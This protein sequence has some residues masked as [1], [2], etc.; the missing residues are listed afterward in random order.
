VR[1][2]DVR[3]AL[4]RKVLKEHHGDANT[5]NPWNLIA[6]CSLVVTLAPF[7]LALEA[8]ENRWRGLPTRRPQSS[9]GCTIQYLLSR[10]RHSNDLPRLPAMMA[11]R[12]TTDKVPSAHRAAV[13]KSAVRLC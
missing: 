5:L 11:R 6:V 12:F 10:E 2:R 13:L 9:L 7:E 1:D 4:H 8:T 3:Q